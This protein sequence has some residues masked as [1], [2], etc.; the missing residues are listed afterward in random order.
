MDSAFWE[1]ILV[2]TLINAIV[3]LG[4]YVTL[5]SGQLS[6]AH[7]AL[8]GVGAYVAGILT[9]NF[10]WPYWPALGAGALGGALFGAA[11]AAPTS[12]M[13]L[14]VQNLTTVAYGM[15]L[16]IVAYNIPYLGGA[17]S[18]T[19]MKT[20][21]TLGTVVAMFCLS[22][23]VTWTIDRSRIGLAARAVRESEVAASVLGISV[24]HIRV[25]TFAI[26]GALA[27]LAG[28]LSAHYTL[29]VNP[30][31]L[32]FYPAFSIVVYVLVGGSYTPLGAVL[33]A[34]LLGI[35]PQAL[36]FADAYRFA[37]YGMMIVL[38]VLRRPDGLLTRGSWNT[39]RRSSFLTGRFWR[40]RG[41]EAP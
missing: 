37:L 11:I 9:V 18:F 20:Y 2:G 33:G 41:S 16:S 19:G 10:F 38:I 39:L 22:F 5:S 17:Q 27:G 21:T 3:A 34:L 35:V 1:P 15:A 29:V 32:G 6:A 31:E 23:Y 25:L 26:G 24:S 7:A 36:R 30:A 28:G 8:M 4:L 40:R 13:R 14:F 12:H